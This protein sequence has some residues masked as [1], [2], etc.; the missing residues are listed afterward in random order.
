MP[1][2]SAMNTTPVD[3]LNHRPLPPRRTDIGIGVV[4]AGFIVRDCHLVAYA[5]AGF[6]VVGITSRSID[7][8]R[9]VAELRAVPH[10]FESV[11][12]MVDDPAIEV[13]DIAVPPN[14]QSGVIDRVLSH[15]RRVRGILAV[16]AVDRVDVYN[17]PSPVAGDAARRWAITF[18]AA[19]MSAPPTAATA[20]G[21]AARRSASAG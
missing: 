13:I 20:G 1:T 10:V 6:R 21:P 8:A 12:E 11:E 3:S 19:A 9:E 5:E 14:D 17:S 7:K 18:L 16:L 4:G 15:R 2:S